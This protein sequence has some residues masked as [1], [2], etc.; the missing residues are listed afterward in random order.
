LAV[1][2]DCEKRFEN[3]VADLKKLVDELQDDA[4]SL[5]DN[6]DWKAAGTIIEENPD[7]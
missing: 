5:A 3:G 7:L 1:I 4:N 6:E 2:P